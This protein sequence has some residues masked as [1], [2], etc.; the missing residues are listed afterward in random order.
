MDSLEIY[1][2]L[3]ELEHF[4]E[5]ARD[6]QNELL[7]MDCKGCKDIRDSILVQINELMEFSSNIEKEYKKLM[8]FQP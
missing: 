2:D 7:D 3:E 6:K 8:E 4:R 5:W 1:K